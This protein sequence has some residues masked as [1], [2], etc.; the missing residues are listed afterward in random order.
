ME[1]ILI[2]VITAASIGFIH[3]VLGPDHYIP[4]VATSKAGRR[5]VALV[6]CPVWR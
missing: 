3:T 5:P 6:R 4:F 2:L 1:S